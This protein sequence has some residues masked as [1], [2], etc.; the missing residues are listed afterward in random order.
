MRVLAANMVSVEGQTGAT[1]NAQAASNT[2]AKVGFATELS[3]RLVFKPSPTD[4]AQAS[5]R[6]GALGIGKPSED[7]DHSRQAAGPSAGLQDVTA[8]PGSL[9][10]TTSP[11]D[12]TPSTITLIEAAALH[13]SSTPAKI[14]LKDKLQAPSA[15]GVAP[16]QAAA[17]SSPTLP[18]QD[19]P[20]PQERP[21]SAS[22]AKSASPNNALPAES[23]SSLT[24]SRP[25]P[26]SAVTQQRPA[27][28]MTILEQPASADSTISSRISKSSRPAEGETPA[29]LHNALAGVGIPQPPSGAGPKIE[30]SPSKS[31]KDPALSQATPNV[32]DPPPQ[33]SN[34]ART[35]ASEQHK[36]VDVAEHASDQVPAAL[37]ANPIQSSEVTEEPAIAALSPSQYVIAEPE[38]LAPSRNATV[39]SA[40]TRGSKA[41]LPNDLNPLWTAAPDAPNMNHLSNGPRSALAETTT[42]LSIVSTP[43]QV[44]GP[45]NGKA[46]VNTES[47]SG[48]DYTSSNSA[49]KTASSL[50]SATTGSEL[51]ST[52][53]LNNPKSAAPQ[54]KDSKA[55]ARNQGTP[56]NEDPALVPLSTARGIASKQ[57]Q[58]GSGGGLNLSSK[59]SV[60]AIE[61]NGPASGLENAATQLGMAN[62]RIS[63]R[64]VGAGAPIQ[65]TA[66]HSEPQA[67]TG[68]PQST[69]PQQAASAGESAGGS[70]DSVAPS[71]DETMTPFVVPDYSL[72]QSFGS[73]KATSSLNE[74]E[75]VSSGRSENPQAVSGT[76]QGPSGHGAPIPMPNSLAQAP[77]QTQDNEAD[78]S[79]CDTRQPAAS[80]HKNDGDAVRDPTK[81]VD[82]KPGLPK[83]TLDSPASPQFSI[84]GPPPTGR[85]APQI[86]GAP[87][88]RAEAANTSLPTGYQAA[89]RESVSS[90][91]FT[92]QAGSAEMQVKLRTESLGPI[93]VRTIVRG[94][95]IGASIRVEARETQ[96]MMSNEI[97][98]L[99]QALSER[100]LRVQRLDV[101]QGSVSGGQS[102]GTG[103]GSYQGNPSRS[104]QGS[105]SY[106]GDGTYPTLPE[107]P[108]VYEEGSL[109]LSTTRINLRA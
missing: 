85:A 75:P 83:T 69:V 101:L 27:V 53:S 88:G 73:T 6:G 3:S 87:Q 81:E 51:Q 18:S 28:T 93:D 17:S 23:G 30:A 1:A 41:A 102:S 90:A 50:S 16:T 66:T 48:P 49:I 15:V 89:V 64:A 25:T 95:D 72:A 78:P 86:V 57:A 32:V 71:D 61:S 29:Q 55:S 92:Q 105:A 14:T 104:R 11:E 47:T 33:P 74:G 91:R 37:G 22:S 62:P 44:Q 77:V 52:S 82:A 106:T 39:A 80:G 26:H 109:G 20:K 12:N 59:A 65:Q 54:E 36:S 97:S 35:N 2:Q 67:P 5:V 58:P 70:Y 40:S 10:T 99:E 38:P 63:V 24:Q 100:S 98:R 13:F 19:P 103:P 84:Q 68:P 107:T 46:P 34:P 42:W 21:T 76:A 7:W 94:S 79:V 56:F 9:P 96:M 8:P 31:S 108:P 45:A 43:A 60:T 4:P